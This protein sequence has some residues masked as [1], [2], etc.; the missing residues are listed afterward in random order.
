[1][2]RIVTFTANPAVDISTAT[3]KLTPFSK[4]RCS[5]A[6]KDPG[7]GGINVARV[8]H[9]L[10]GEA[11]AV[12]PAGGTTGRALRHLTDDEGVASLEIA[13]AA[14]TRQNITVVENESGAQY[15]FIFPGGALTEAEEE[16]CLE[17]LAGLDPRP[18]FLVAS[19][20]LP[21]GAREDF[22]RRVAEAGKRLGAKVIV[23]SFGPPLKQALGVGLH[24][25]KPNLREFRQLTGIDGEDETGWIAAA[26]RL[27][28]DGGV[29]MVALTLG[30]HGAL[31]VG[32]RF[33]FRADPLPVDAVSVSGAGDSFLAAMTWVL[34]EG[35]T[36]EEALRYGVAAG[37]AAV[38]QPG[39]ELCR[40]DDVKRLAG[41]VV[42]RE[43]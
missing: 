5:P 6:Q 16:R 23:D 37:S 10:G 31:L 34:A 9:R 15:R 18:G 3:D 4:L 30:E 13:I 38:L 20:S 40:A 24:L 12:Y 43:I 32:G 2:S 33:V 41:D 22:L 27:I 42:V 25:V 8:V 11:L 39:T 17:A 14:E 19:G 36:A 28:A 26:R 35:G 21:P 29:A 1:L 7:G